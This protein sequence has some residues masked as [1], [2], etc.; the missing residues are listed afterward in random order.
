MKILI[1]NQPLNN[2]GDESAHK[3]LVRKLINEIPNVQIKV[4]WVGSNQ[5]S[6]NQ[7]AVRSPKV[8]YL[9]IKPHK[10][11]GRSL[12]YG[13][14]YGLKFLWHIHPTIRKIMK[15]YQEADY[16]MCAPGG[17][18]MGGFQNWIHITTLVIAKDLGKPIFYYGRSFG[19][20]P[21]E[22]KDNRK[23]KGISIKL[24][25]YFSFLSV[26]DNKSELLAQQMKLKYV[27][28]VDSA[29]L[30]SPK[31]DIPL[32]ISKSIGTSPYMVFVPNLLIWHYAY[33][34]RIN[35]E[36][37]LTFYSKI[38]DVINYKYPELK[39]VM[40]PQTFNYGSYTGDD[41]HLFNDIKNLKKDERLVVIPDCY[42]SDIQQ[43]IISHAKFLIGARYHSVVFALNQA[44]PFIAL[45]YEHKISGLL[46]T[47]HKEDCMIDITHALDSDGNMA[48]AIGQISSKLDHIKG[49]K[50]A[51]QN[52]KSIAEACFRQ[53]KSTYF[54]SNVS[55]V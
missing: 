20:F 4:L 43:T 32:E 48:S 13:V 38:I 31:V 36:I 40:L 19:P 34:G 54:E 51:K 9:N 25:N 28:T 41:I 39:I 47:L 2:R 35:K 16:V 21:T 17:I 8:E 37:V 29:F 27:S 44:I 11:Y 50:E 49:D 52:A 18:C 24:L 14:K 42:S 1:V 22:T 46:E 30:D 53:L 45:S 26:R 5:D 10:A 3:G 23:F 55:R 33:K 15:L 6:I 7:F 12:I